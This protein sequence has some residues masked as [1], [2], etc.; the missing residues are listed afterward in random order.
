MSVAEEL[1]ANLT[2]SQQAAV[3]SDKRRLLVVAGA[4]SG[5]TEVMARRV[6]W[7]IATQAVPKDS[8]VAFTFTDA[9]AEELK[10]RIRRHVQAITPAG[11]DVTLGGMYVGT[12][13][14][15]CLKMLRELEPD[16]YHNYDVIEEGA[17]LA[18]V[19]RAFHSILGLKEFQSALGKGQYQVIDAFLEAY[20]LLNEYALLDVELPSKDAPDAI[21][22]EKEWSKKATLRTDVGKTPLAKAFAQSAAR[23]YAYLHCRRFLDFSTSQVELVRLLEGSRDLLVRVRES[24]THLVVDE[25]QDINPVQ[26][27]IVNLIV[28]HKGHLT[29][30]GDHRQAIYGWRGGRVD[31]MG[32]LH[33]VLKSSSDGGVKEL[34][35][36]FRSTPRIVGVANL[37]AAGIGQVRGMKTG[38]MVGGRESRK[39]RSPAHV[40]TLRFDSRDAEAEWIA[41]SINRLVKPGSDE[42]AWHDTKDGRR[43]LGYADIAVLLRSSTDARTYMNALE[44]NGI[45][46]VFRAGPDLFSQPEVLLFVAALAHAAGID[47][48]LGSDYNPK[49]LPRR[50]QDVLGCDAKPLDALKAGCE[51]ARGAGLPITSD[52]EARL[53]LAAD[54][55]RKRIESN[56][57]A[58]TGTQR[59]QLRNEKLIQWLAGRT[60]I[61]RVFPQS[62][63]QWLLAE[64]DVG[65][66][67]VAGHRGATAMFHLGQLSSLVKSIET[68]G[69]TSSGDFKYQMIALGLWGAQNARTEEAPLL[70]QPD[71][72]LISTVHGAKGLE[73]GA[74]FLA[75]VCSRRFPSQRARTKPDL[76]F[77]GPILKKINPAQLADNQNLDQERRLMYVGLTRGERYLYVTSSKPS[78]FFTSVEEHVK[79]QGGIAGKASSRL[80][81]GLEYN[82]TE[83]DR[84]AR[85]VTSFS[86][87]RYFLECPHDFYLRKV[88]GFAPTIDQAFGY[89]RGVHNLLRAIHSDP[90][91]WAKLA[92]DPA[93][94]ENGL[95]DLVGRGL[96]YL[97]YTTGE[98]ADN[99]REKAIRLAKQYVIEHASELERLR[100]EPEREFE[101]LLEEEKVL[102]SGAIDVVRLDDPPRVTLI[103][104]KSGESESEA[105]AKLD[106][107]EMRLQVSLYGVAAK[108][109]LEYEPERGL[110][111]YLD[112][113]DPE[114]RELEVPLNA[115]ALREAQRI[116]VGA[117]RSIKSRAFHDGPTRE[118]GNG[119]LRCGECDFGDFCGMKKAEEHRS[120]KKR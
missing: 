111:R 24:L 114:K 113:N 42:G 44:R 34:H 68:P 10:F 50:V 110:V 25:V 61:R 63:Y 66:W 64:A 3:K 91:A 79:K 26:D 67:E 109:E 32:T 70:V 19:Q 49:S 9:A 74:V 101:T 12:I 118:G 105:L 88:L 95:R 51:T 82:R 96:F 1:L 120:R 31:I 112:E 43:G 90:T 76:P 30:V 53:G 87:L 47:Q 107:E 78:P 5:K 37:W 62:I 72:V 85:L 48:F 38:D 92:R 102:V 84:D 7:W 40:A 29:A 103:D 100:F 97:R 18:L 27:E 116:V 22:E 36:N 77:D 108:K 16:T 59:K 60:P 45:P 52:A 119:G 15:F 4:G 21:A 71:A 46:A 23:Y 2:S 58:G 104:F 69:W 117:A 57:V 20:D 11:A 80:P 28:G 98:P 17:R 54:L 99:M 106:E 115:N 35:D 93:R 55:I 41:R 81:G 33:D 86:D 6:A 8:I 75:D 94:L 83:F 14:G 13:H 65:A 89:G 56:A 39:D 73:F